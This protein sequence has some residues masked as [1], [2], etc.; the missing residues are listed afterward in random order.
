M[1]FTNVLLEWYRKNRRELPWKEYNDPYSIWVSEVILQQTRVQQGD[2]YFRRFIGAYPTVGHLA[3]APE[4]DVLKLWQGLG[5]YSRARNMHKTAK[6][7][8]E[9]YGGKFPSDINQLKKL[10][11]IGPYTAAAVASF[12]FGM[13]VPALDGNAYRIL[14]RF[15]GIDMPVGTS[16]SKKLFTQ[17]AGILLPRGDSASFNQAMMDFGSLVC[18]PHPTCTSCPMSG[19]CYAFLKGLTDKL[20]VK[21]VKTT[22][23]RRYFNYLDLEYENTIVIRQ[24]TGKD[25]WKGLYEF[26]LIETGTP[27]SFEE[28]TQN[29][30]FRQLTG[31][32]SFTLHDMI[33]LQPHK[34]THQTIYPVFYKI[35]LNGPV[36]VP[37][38]DYRIIDRK[39]LKN[40]AVSRLTEKYMYSF[41]NFVDL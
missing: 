12:A 11:G 19:S 18:T 6:R 8:M 15:F 23:R 41:H 27:V 36:S 10:E 26:P 20:P 25:I 7:I 38:K 35:R 37:E 21:Q 30:D 32:E 5:Y 16:G 3:E 2:G 34:L 33:R 17:L 29:V 4:D 31:L 22:T 24:R 13:D 1:D 39:E 28:L 14:A 40:F 9:E